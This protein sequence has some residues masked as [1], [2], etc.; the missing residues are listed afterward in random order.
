M[1][2]IGILGGLAVVFI[3]LLIYQRNNDDD[4]LD[5]KGRPVKRKKQYY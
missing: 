2:T 5:W 4:R 3:G 1:L